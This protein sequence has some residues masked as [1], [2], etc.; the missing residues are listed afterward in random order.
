VI[1]ALAIELLQNAPPDL[2][3][4]ISRAT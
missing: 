4:W 2:G 1:D 3:W